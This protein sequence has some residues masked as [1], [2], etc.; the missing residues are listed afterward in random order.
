MPNDSFW[1][2]RRLMYRFLDRLTPDDVQAIA[3]F[4]QMEMLEAG[5]AT[6]VEFHYLH[7]DAG[8]QPFADLAE[9][10]ARIAA[11][12]EQSGIG[13]T[14]LPVLYQHGGLDGRPLVTGQDRFGNDP[15]RFARLV[16]GARGHVAALP[17]DARARRRAAQP[18]RGRC[19][20]VCP[21]RWRWPVT[22]RSTCTWPN[23][24]PRS[25]RCWP[26]PAAAPSN[27][28]WTTRRSTRAGA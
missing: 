7:H 18:A 11:A 5:Y 26:P 16:D 3:A 2:W 25:T 4:V 6:N 15:D 19:R 28:C 23:S 27:G 17:A 24:R 12:A 9:M 1:T 13:L 10:S 20:R 8:G 14:L 21:P 22:A